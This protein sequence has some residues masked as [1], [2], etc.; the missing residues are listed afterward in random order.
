MDMRACLTEREV[1]EALRLLGSVLLAV[2]RNVGE[3]VVVLGL[4]RAFDL[5]LVEFA[6]G[7]GEPALLHAR[8]E[9]QVGADLLELVFGR[10][11]SQ[12]RE[13]FLE[14]VQLLLVV[15]VELRSHRRARATPFAA[16]VVSCTSEEHPS[17]RMVGSHRLSQRGRDKALALRWG[18]DR[19]VAY[20]EE[21]V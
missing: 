13:M 3:R 5:F 10:R 18:R 17:L 21:V 14:N 7:L 20:R 11:S 9:V 2:L 8:A 4:L 1:G 15:N 16:R 12:V 19:R 6:D